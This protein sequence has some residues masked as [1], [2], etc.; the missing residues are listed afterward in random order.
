MKEIITGAFSYVEHQ[1]KSIRISY[2]D[3][4]VGGGSYEAIYDINSVNRENLERLLACH[5]GSLKQKITAEF[6]KCL[7]K[8]SFAE[9]CDQ[10]DVKYELFTWIDE[11][12]D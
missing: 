9:F 8:K 7:E 4:F 3:S 10:N 12:W 1:D 11:D 5:A 2:E 6:G